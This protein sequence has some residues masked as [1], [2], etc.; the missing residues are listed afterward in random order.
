MS[1]SRS[2]ALVTVAYVV[3]IGV[4]AAWL[5]WGPASD[6]LWLDTLIADV[7]ATLVVFGF[8]RAYHNSSFYDAY[9]S[10]IPPLLAVYWWTQA[11]PGADQLRR[12]LV[13]VVVVLWA[14][15]LTANWVYAFP[16]LHHE[17][18][19]YPKFRERAGRWEFVVDLVAIHLI[20]TVEVFAGM[21]PVYVC[22]TRPGTG[23]GWLTW[24]AFVIGLAAVAL[25]L[26]ADVQMHRFVRVRQPGEVMD[27]GLWSWSR[28]P[29]YFGEFSFWFALALFGVAASPRDA[30]WLFV[31]ALAMLAMFLGAS[32]P[33]M[34]ARSL[35]RRPG[36]QAVIDRVPRFVPRPPRRRAA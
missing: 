23:I 15:R 35:E 18:W 16:G 36:Y 27:R 1:K 28:H 11:G 2:L 17:D 25:E 5:A 4:A 8:S 12:W 26:A 13:M 7:L 24:I 34:E 10:V 3:A 20:P 33:M 19:R 32:I 22:L 21:L 6:K 14:V 30:W 31:G 29:N 9:W